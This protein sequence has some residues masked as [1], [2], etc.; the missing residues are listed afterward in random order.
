M[1]GYTSRLD[2]KPLSC[3]PPIIITAEIR[4]I[5]LIYLFTYL[6]FFLKKKRKKKERD[7]TKIPL[8]RR[9]LHVRYTKLRAELYR[10]LAG[11]CKRKAVAEICLR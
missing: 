1:H 8:P 3:V 2:D 11:R 10:N 9:E 6:L 4:A 5:L 7:L